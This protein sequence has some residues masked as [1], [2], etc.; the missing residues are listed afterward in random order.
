MTVCNLGLVIGLAEISDPV[1]ELDPF[2]GLCVILGRI[3][4]FGTAQPPVGLSVDALVPFDGEGSLTVPL[5][6]VKAGFSHWRW[7]VKRVG[8]LV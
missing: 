4:V 8:D 5:R 6:C 3:R 1:L 2:P 7:L